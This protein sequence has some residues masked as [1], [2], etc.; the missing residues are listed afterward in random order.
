MYLAFC[1]LQMLCQLCGATNISVPRFQKV[2]E[3]HFAQHLE[4]QENLC[5]AGPSMTHKKHFQ[6]HLH[7]AAKKSLSQIFCAHPGLIPNPQ[8]GAP[9]TA[10]SAIICFPTLTNPDTHKVIAERL[11]VLSSTCKIPFSCPEDRQGQAAPARDHST[12]PHSHQS[13][14]RSTSG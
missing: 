9:C 12:I 6:P 14:V 13:F 5:Q 3:P 1:W 8:W 2:K 11:Q 7:R 10:I 4:I